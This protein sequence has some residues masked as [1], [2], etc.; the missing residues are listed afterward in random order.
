MKKGMYIFML[1]LGCTALFA[2]VSN[3]D[4][5]MLDKEE[6]EIADLRQQVTDLHKQIEKR[7]AA[8]AQH[9]S[10]A[11]IRHAEHNGYTSETAPK[12]KACA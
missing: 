8:H 1:T 6:A 11:H 9:S 3:E 10:A 5:A 12:A 4:K 7:V 2:A